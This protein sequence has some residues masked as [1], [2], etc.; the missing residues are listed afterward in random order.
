M[1]L[2]QPFTP[3]SPR[4]RLRSDAH[5]RAC[6]PELPPFAYYF[7]SEFATSPTPNRAQIEITSAPRYPQHIH[8]CWPSS[9]LRRFNSHKA[10][11]QPPRDNTFTPAQLRVSTFTTTPPRLCSDQTTP[12]QRPS[13]AQPTTKQSLRNHY[14]ATTKPLPHN[15]DN[16]NTPPEKPS[17]I[18]SS[19]LAVHL[20]VTC[21]GTT[22]FP[23]LGR[24][25]SGYNPTT[26]ETHS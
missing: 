5:I 20:R 13:K 26:F 21:A 11:T 24:V 14:H 17:L 1:P 9:Q 18:T 15:R 3:Y 25:Q 7:P 12:N 16:P 4:R 22:P 10:T 19:S 6:A 23:H 8:I 2:Q